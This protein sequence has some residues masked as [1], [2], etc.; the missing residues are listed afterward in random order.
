MPHSPQHLFAIRDDLELKER[1]ACRTIAYAALADITDQ[2]RARFTWSHPDL[3]KALGVDKRFVTLL[4][5][6]LEYRRS[7]RVASAERAIRPHGTRQAQLY[8]V[9]D[10]M[11]MDLINL[12]STDDRMDQMGQLL[13]QASHRKVR[14]APETAKSIEQMLGRACGMQWEAIAATFQRQRQA[15]DSAAVNETEEMAA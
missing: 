5:S 12:G 14:V 1:Q 8:R 13:R 15:Q 3:A 11:P 7:Q 2:G 4:S 10:G 6:Y 9:S